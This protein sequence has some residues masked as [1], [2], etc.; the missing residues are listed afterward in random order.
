MAKLAELPPDAGIA[1]IDINED[2][3][4]VVMGEQPQP[5]QPKMRTAEDLG[6]GAIAREF[7]RQDVKHM[8]CNTCA[9]P[10]PMI[11]TGLCDGCWEVQSRLRAYI[12]KGPKAATFVMN[13]LA[14][15]SG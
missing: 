1:K 4:V 15:R 9:R 10:T 13:A 8:P 2:G 5:V 11:A 12:D 3:R 14:A 6:Y 7:D